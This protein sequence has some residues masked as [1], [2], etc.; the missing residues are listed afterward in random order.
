M[1]EGRQSLTTGLNFS[2][3]LK[4]TAGISYTRFWGGEGD[5]LINAAGS[6]LNGGTDRDFVAVNLKYSF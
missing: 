1:V 4:Y 5:H 6:R 2:Y 3:L